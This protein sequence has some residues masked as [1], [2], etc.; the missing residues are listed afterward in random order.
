M[1][2]H[3][4]LTLASLLFASPALLSCAGSTVAATDSSPVDATT[5]AAPDSTVSTDAPNVKNIHADYAFPVDTLQDWVTYGDVFVT[6]TVTKAEPVPL[7]KED[8]ERSEG[9]LTESY[10]TAE[11]EEIH[12]T[13][14]G[15]S[16]IPPAVTFTWLAGVRT[17][18]RDIPAVTNSGQVLEVGNRY[19]GLFYRMDSDRWRPLASETLAGV[20]PDG[21]V[22]V[23]N[24]APSS[25]S[26]ASIDGKSASEVGELLSTTPQYADFSADEDLTPLERYCRVAE[27]GGP[28]GVLGL[29]PCEVAA[30]ATSATSSAD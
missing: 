30:T 17:A 9:V 15:A 14:P 22:V 25:S 16:S 27:A 6:F 10:L 29:D 18:G 4:W 2:G 23:P 1:V 20:G 26:Q 7:S 19:V 28:K 21:L 5:G 11:I 3:C 8:A 13:H 12:W 24:R